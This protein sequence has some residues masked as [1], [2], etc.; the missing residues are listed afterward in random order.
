MEEFFINKIN[1]AFEKTENGITKLPEE[2]FKINGMSGKKTRIFYNNLLEMDKEINYLEMGIFLGSTFISS[3]YKNL[4]VKGYA[5]DSFGNYSMGIQP[6]L[7]NLNLHLINNEKYVITTE[8]CFTHPIN[9]NIKD[10]KFQVFLYDAGH[11]K[12]DHYNALLFYYDILDDIFIYIVDDWNYDDVRNGTL[13]SFKN[14]NVTVLY[15][16]EIRLTDDGTTTPE[17][18]LSEGYWNGIY[19]AVL[20]KNK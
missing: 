3:M 15:E 8:H 13:E 4:N 11:S 14:A 7:D 10:T 20:S 2:I 6:F 17:P 16:K 19:V 12:D 18:L 1:E 5:F 9:K